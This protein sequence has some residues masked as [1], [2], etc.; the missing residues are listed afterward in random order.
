MGEG[1]GVMPLRA[2]LGF[3]VYGVI[4]WGGC[5]LRVKVEGLR[6]AAWSAKSRNLCALR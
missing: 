1:E 6:G 5:G 4:F 2:G 3:G